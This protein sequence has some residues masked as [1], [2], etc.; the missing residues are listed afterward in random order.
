MLEKKCKGCKQI[1]LL[2]EFY[3]C[4]NTRDRKMG[5]CIKCIKKQTAFWQQCNPD[6][7]QAKNA[8]WVAKNKPLIYTLEQRQELF[9]KQEGRCAICSR[10]ESEFNRRLAVD[11]CHATGAIRGLLC[12]PCNRGLG[13]FRDN[14]ERL[15]KA[16]Q[17]IKTS[18]TVR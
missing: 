3:N 12:S 13:L 2:E 17:Y 10:H 18:P 4:K 5:K 9:D 11:H 8:R 15:I 6:K 1:K 7:C 14:Q 16:A